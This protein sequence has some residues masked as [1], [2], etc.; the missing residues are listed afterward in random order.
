VLRL[1]IAFVSSSLIARQL[2]FPFLQ[3]FASDPN[4]DP[5]SS[6]VDGSGSVDAFPYGVL[7][8][9]LVTI[10]P[11]GERA[12]AIAISVIVLVSDIRC[13]QWLTRRSRHQKVNIYALVGWWL[14]PAY[15]VGSYAFGTLDGLVA[16]L[17]LVLLLAVRNSDVGKSLI[18]LA[19]VGSLKTPLL[20]L[21]PFVI[22]LAVHEISRSGVKRNTQLI[23]GILLS[24][25]TSLPFLYSGGFRTMVFESPELGQLLDVAF[26]LSETVDVSLVSTLIICSFIWLLSRSRV[27][28]QHVYVSS[29]VVLV[30]LSL[31]A[32][33]GIGWFVWTGPLLVSDRSFAGKRPRAILYTL[34]LVLLVS[35]WNLYGPALIGGTDFFYE[36]GL[37]LRSE[38]LGF[39]VLPLGASAIAIAVKFY[40]RRVDPLHTERRPLVLA[41]A[42]DSATGKSTLADSI[43]SCFGHKNVFKV[44]GDDFHRFDRRSSGWER[45]THLD[46]SGNRLPEM[47]QEVARLLSGEQ[48][49]SLGYDHS[50]GRFSPRLRRADRPVVIVEG[51]HTIHLEEVSRLSDVKVFLEVEEEWRVFAKVTRDTAER[52]SSPE[53]IRRTIE[54]RRPDYVRHVLPQ[55]S[56]ADLVFVVNP[57]GHPSPDLSLENISSRFEHGAITVATEDRMFLQGFAHDLAMVTPCSYRLSEAGSLCGLTVKPGFLMPEDFSRL[58]TFTSEDVRRIFPLDCS[59]LHGGSGFMAVVTIKFAVHQRLYQVARR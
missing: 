11:L 12:F 13:Y 2:Y 6:W 38:L 10:V 42:G 34:Q 30:T 31:V 55:R 43:S 51:L 26:P 27:T 4:V 14:G 8:L 52:G 9:A 35:V 3:A 16:G 25:L 39:L 54:L 18:L 48:V 49:N 23:V 22:L 20:V 59:L 5:W 32:P 41:V 45:F 17:L 24:F 37:N 33:S 1:L 50:S 28:G 53:S 7:A 58:L 19:I 15:L 46:V 57:R 40:S 56:S 29:L 36:A 21:Y 47:S 44:A